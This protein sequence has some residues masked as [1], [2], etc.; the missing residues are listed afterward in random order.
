MIVKQIVDMLM[1]LQLATWIPKPRILRWLKCGNLLVVPK[2][3]ILSGMFE[4]VYLGIV[5]IVA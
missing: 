2:I 5:I 4:I 3:V 1:V